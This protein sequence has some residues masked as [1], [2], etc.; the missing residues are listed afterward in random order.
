MREL[1]DLPN[2]RNLANM[3]DS[4]PTLP[5]ASTE[6][7]GREATPIPDPRALPAFP[8][9]F[10]WGAATASYQVEG[11]VNEDGRRPSIWDTYS[12]TPGKVLGGDTGDVA[13]DHYHRYRED[14]A[15]MAALGLDAYRFSVA[16]PRIQPDGRGPANQ[17]GLD[18]YRRLLDALDE[19]GIAANLTLF[20]WDLPQALEDAGGWM[21]RD[22][23]QRFADYAAIVGEAFRDRVALWAPTNEA[24]VHWSQ[25]YAVG[26]HAPG[27]TLLFDA[28]PA[29]HH[30]LLGHGLAVNALRAAGVTGRIGTV[31]NHSVVRPASADPGNVAAAGLYDVLRNWLFSDPVLVGAYP[32]ELEAAIPDVG[33]SFA[34]PDDA[35]IIAAPLDFVGVNFYNPEV[36]CAVADSPLGFDWV[37]PTGEVTGFGWAVEPDALRQTLVGLRGRYGDRLPPVYITENGAAYPD[38]PDADGRVHDPGRIRYLDGHLRAVRAAMEEGVDVRGYFAWSLLDNFEWSVGYSQRFGIVHVDFDTLRRT[39]KSSCGWYRDA[40]AGTRP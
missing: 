7:E 31:N 38:A 33:F 17:R 19:R 30:L 18:F 5:A 16:W 37:E 24:F 29:A 35:A 14:V 34:L 39:P 2:L 23:A 11:A 27:R 13:C 20:H 8:P 10:V 32:P 6:P 12:H 15:L 9:G 3:P 28:F 22:T 36:I 25:G 4:P 21:A 40:I 26:T 1:P